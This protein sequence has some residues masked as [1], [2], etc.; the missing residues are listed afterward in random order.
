MIRNFINAAHKRLTSFEDSR[1]ICSVKEKCIKMTFLSRFL[2]F[3]R[4]FCM[5]VCTS[6]KQTL[7]FRQTITFACIL[8][9]CRQ[10]YFVSS[11]YLSIRDC[12]SS[13][14]AKHLFILRDHL[15]NQ[16]VDEGHWTKRTCCV[17]CMQT[18]PL[19]CVFHWPIKIT[20]P[21]SGLIHHS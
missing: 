6:S 11:L 15:L 10:Q 13:L 20:K 14:K 8:K 9:Y 3:T 4:G 21:L 1:K 16:H 18:Y 5:C 17:I 7:L 2:V 19:M 12:W